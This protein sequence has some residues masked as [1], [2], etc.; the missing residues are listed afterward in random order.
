[1][2]RHPQIVETRQ[3]YLALVLCPPL[4]RKRIFTMEMV[5]AV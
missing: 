2:V 4:V 1:M 5:L 3:Y